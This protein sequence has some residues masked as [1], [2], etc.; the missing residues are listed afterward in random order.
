MY[1]WGVATPTLTQAVDQFLAGAGHSRAGTSTQ[2]SYRYALERF[3]KAAALSTVADLKSL[4]DFRKALRA[5]EQ[6]FEPATVALTVSAVRQFYRA[7]QV[8]DP[9][10]K[11]PTVGIR[12]HIPDNVPEWNVLQQG[13]PAAMLEKIKEP[14]HRAVFLALVMQGWRESE[15][16]AMT[17]KNVRQEG[18]GWVVEWKAKRG[19]MRRQALQAVVMEAVRACGGKVAPGAPLIPNVG[20]KAFTRHEVYN[21]VKKYSKLFGRRVTPHGL[22]ATYISS[23]IARK[24]IEAAR[25]LAGHKSIATTQRYSRW[26]IDSDDPL[27]VEDL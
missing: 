8:D 18:A 27:T 16:C 3:F 9:E 22:R 14:R 23:V 13:D 24:G 19:K 20:G 1:S 26:L 12:V 11:D 21:L 15:L 2:T 10:L 5:L 25:Q 7:L 6:E 17:W 4:T